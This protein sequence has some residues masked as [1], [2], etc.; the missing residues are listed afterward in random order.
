MAEL[1]DKA[2]A[3]KRV[4]LP[5]DLTSYPIVSLFSYPL[6][7]SSQAPGS[8]SSIRDETASPDLTRTPSNTTKPGASRPVFERP[9]SPPLPSELV[10][11]EDVLIDRYFKYCFRRQ[12]QNK[13]L[14]GSILPAFDSIRELIDTNMALK[15][16]VCSLAA[17]TF[18]YA[19]PS[20]NEVLTHLTLALALLRE[21]LANQ[22][23]DEGVLLAIIELVEVEVRLNSCPCLDI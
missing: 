15:H 7:L 12:F 16:A 6:W 14:L 17:L 3:T 20:V 8:S 2:H 21:M 11:R 5:S 1:I 10:A 9:I 4:K 18:P 19:E 22:P 13:V 23:C